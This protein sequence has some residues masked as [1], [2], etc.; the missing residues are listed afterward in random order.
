MAKTP[1]TVNDFL[2]D[3]RVQLAPGG[4]KETEHL[5]ELK[6]EDLAS[7]GLEA[8]NDGNYYLWDT[9]FYNRIMVE[10][11]FSIDE[12]DIANYFPLQSTIEGMLTIFEE[13][14]GFV[15]VEIDSA[16]RAKLSGRRTFLTSSYISNHLR[17]WKGRRYLL[18][19]RRE[20][21]QRLG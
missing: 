2:D 10:K 15:F 8:S 17:N 14:F 19:R 20:D 12:Q 7:R 21:F 4:V 3:L 11:E 6:K 5:K 13:L 18:A 9:R 16:E 1:K